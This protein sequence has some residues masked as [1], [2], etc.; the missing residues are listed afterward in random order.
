MKQI[1]LLISIFLTLNLFGQKSDI[2]NLISQVAKVE[3][4]E[5]FEYYFLVPKSLE[6]EKIDDSLQN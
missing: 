2:E 3:I 6:Q 5:N 4:P 1:L